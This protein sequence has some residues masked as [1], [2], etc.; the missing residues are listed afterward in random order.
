LT[1]TAQPHSYRRFIANVLASGAGRVAAILLALV[2][3]TV[4][5]HTLG[6]ARYGVWSF[7]FVLIG[8]ASLFDFGLSVAVERAV[9]R[10]H[11]A[12]DTADVGRT[13]SLA[14]TL[15][16]ALS[17]VLQTI[18]LLVPALS[19][20]AR[21]TFDDAGAAGDVRDCLRVLPLCLFFSNAGA[22][23]GGALS[24][25][26]RQA[27]L[28]ALRTGVGG[29]TTL[30]V[31]LLAAGGMTR[32]DML[33]T[34]YAAGLFVTGAL[35]WRQVRRHLVVDQVGAE[36]QGAD[37]AAP[38]LTPFTVDRA[39]LREF[40][41]VAGA[42][43][44]STLALQV[45]DQGLRWLLG[46][47]FGA[48]TMGAYDLAARAGVALRSLSG[49]LVAAMVPFGAGRAAAIGDASL[50]QL[51]QLAVKY[52]ALFILA[53][54][55]AALAQSHAIVALWL[56]SIPTLP[57]VL[58]LFQVL[59][60]AHGLMALA[61]PAAAIGRATG[62]AAPEAIVLVLA[63]SLGLA[64]A[65]AMTDAWWS[66]AAFAGC[67]TVGGF[68]L[69]IVLDRALDLG[70]ARPADAARL[71]ATLAA[72]GVIV[73]SASRAA[74]LSVPHAW[75]RVLLVSAVSA[76]TVAALA[77]ALGLISADERRVLRRS[78]ASS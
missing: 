35:A 48:E 15:A 43:Q 6:P 24:G 51:Q 75:L 58:A 7:F 76:L 8:Y 16:F 39:R 38:R 69:W 66:V 13:V 67:V 32:L 60:I 2:L 14:L 54:T 74:D 70:G 44:V 62:R 49:A 34:V 22:A 71:A 9:A 61:G 59:L 55:A 29:L 5:V 17:V 42:V 20:L 50:A 63:N 47:R 28:Q 46:A 33:L 26:Q 3:A 53:G 57:L 37:V 77:A 31:A 45:G 23:A 18:V 21:A 27:S 73:W 40:V 30:A 65:A 19:G 11:A 1:P 36:H 4:L 72:T 78:R 12:H 10:A 52:V 68:V 25:I 56:G 41:R 64:L